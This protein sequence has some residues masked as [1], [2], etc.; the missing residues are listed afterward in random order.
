MHSR[1]T[2]GAGAGRGRQGEHRDR[3]RVAQRLEHGLAR[4][5]VRLDRGSGFSR[6]LD[7]AEPLDPPEEPT[8]GAV[9][10]SR[11]MLG[12]VPIPPFSATYGPIRHAGPITSTPIAAH[13]RDRLIRSG[14]QKEEDE[15]GRDQA[16]RAAGVPRAG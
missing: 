14:R 12:L 10:S 2:S 16:R 7:G 1:D 15:E 3:D 5:G 11:A 13:H 4:Q 8:L 6:S 9:P